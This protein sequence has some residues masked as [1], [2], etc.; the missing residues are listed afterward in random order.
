MSHSNPRKKALRNIF[1]IR[2]VTSV[3]RDE[4]VVVGLSGQ[5]VG[6][7]RVSCI[8]RRMRNLVHERLLEDPVRRVPVGLAGVD[9]Q[10]AHEL[11]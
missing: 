11:E 1:T 9:E 4:L 5:P 6:C 7:R 8:E 10:V 3:G 2:I